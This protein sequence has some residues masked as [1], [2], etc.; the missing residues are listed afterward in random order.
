MPNVPYPYEKNWHLVTGNGSFISTCFLSNN[1]L[2]HLG[3]Y[4]L[5]TLVEIW[6]TDLSK[7]G[8]AMALSSAK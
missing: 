1:S 8:G 7:S 3:E 6:L 4:N 5:S 2:L